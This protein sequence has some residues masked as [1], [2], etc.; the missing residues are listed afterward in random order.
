MR[1]TPNLRDTFGSGDPL[2]PGTVNDVVDLA[3]SAG[4]DTL[5]DILPIDPPASA[6]FANVRFF[7]FPLRSGA[8]IVGDASRQVTVKPLRVGRSSIS[9]ASPRAL[10][11]GASETDTV[12]AMPTV[13]A[14]GQWRFELLYAQLA[15]VDASDP[16]KGTT[17]TYLFATSAADVSTASPANFASLPSSGPTTW[18]IPLFYVKNVGGATSIAAEDILEFQPTINYGGINYGCVRGMLSGRDMR[19]AYSSANQAP[20]LMTTGGSA[21]WAS[22][23]QVLTSVQTGVMA[24]SH[25]A[26][27]F[28]FRE[29]PLAKEKTGP[30]ADILQHIVVD[31]S[32]DWRNANF[33]SLW[34]VVGDASFNHGEDDSGTSNRAAPT[35][36]DGNNAK[37]YVSVGQSFVAVNPQTSGSFGGGSALWAANIGSEVSNGPVGGGTTFAGE[38]LGL[39]V[40]SSTGALR[41]T[42]KRAGSAASGPP[43]SIFLVAIFPNH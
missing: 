12:V 9:N 1:G 21:A 6:S 23:S 24:G 34:S 8:A 33:Y 31:D 38:V 30:N 16:S 10:L 28:V 18:N 14:G 25:G 36:L 15:Y 42:R 19:R 20:N 41:W 11:T 4:D 40:D 22:G 32:R 29:I 26:A 3:T 39:T 13:A 27:E 37:N 35:Q 5:Y 2:P 43:I 7:W 17:V